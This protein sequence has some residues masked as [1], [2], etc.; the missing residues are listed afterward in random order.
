MMYILTTENAWQ[1]IPV[2][3]IPKASGAVVIRVVRAR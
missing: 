1:V 2:Q 3:T